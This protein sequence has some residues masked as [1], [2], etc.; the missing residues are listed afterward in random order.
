MKTT[1]KQSRWL[2]ALCA[3]LL[4]S[5]AALQSHGQAVR[6]RDQGPALTQRERAVHAL[7]RMAFGPRPGDVQ[8]VMEM[9]VERWMKQQLNP[10]SIE[11]N[12]ANSVAGQLYPSVG[13]PNGELMRDYRVYYTPYKN[14]DKPTPQESAQRAREQARNNQLR[15]KIRNELR[16]AVYHRAIY[17][18]RQFEE[19]IVGFWREHFSIDQSKDDVAYFANNWEGQ[20]L[21]RY[22][23][24]KFEDLLLASARHP[25]M[26]VYLDNIVSQKPLTEREERLVERY[27]KRETVPS[28]ILALQRHRGLNENYARELMELHTL[29]VDRQ[30]TQQDVTELAR[31][32]TGW[33][34]GWGDGAM[35]EQM[36]RGKEQL[37]SYHFVFNRDRHDTKD[38]V[39]FGTKL[40]GG[41][42]EQGIM[43]IRALARHPYTADFICRKL[44]AYLLR[45]HPSEA[46]VAHVANVF[47]KTRGDLPKVYEAILFSDDFFF[48]QNHRVKFKTPFEYVVSALR[49]T[50]AQVDRFDAIDRALVKMGQPIYRCPDPTGWYDTSEAWLDPGVLVYRWT[51]A[52]DLAGH[53][54]SGVRVPDGLLADLPADQLR[55]KLAAR[56][57]PSGL[58]ERTERIIDQT[59]GKDA[60]PEELRGVLLGSPDFQQQ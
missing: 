28:S 23:F 15:A 41:G 16:N 21:R 57:L 20:V 37:A 3:A 59:L 60:R 45:D 4:V 58:S 6:E 56:V 39:L 48:R 9:G 36:R 1:L 44:C 8:R 22:A 19:V 52:L 51:F 46:L 55:K 47:R 29:G 13:R 31:V 14:K 34:A 53:G 26:L 24:G 18:N 42:E 25:A 30:Y 5:A 2:K 50:G 11:D 40:K 27:M 32:L 38:K 54:M 43:V 33:S 17:S 35:N 10:R 49:A 12:D 7:N